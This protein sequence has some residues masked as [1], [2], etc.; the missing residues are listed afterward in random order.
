M[1]VETSN[2]YNG[3]N[4][5]QLKKRKQLIPA[6]STNPVSNEGISECFQKFSTSLYLSL[7]PCHISNPIN[8]IKSQHLDS[9]IMTYFP[10]AKGVCLAYSNIKI[11]E[12]NVSKDT[13]DNTITVAKITDSSPFTF[14]WV[15]VDF[16]IWRPQVGDVLEGYIYMQ[17]ASHIGLLVHDT[18]NAS[19]KKF[20]IPVDW[21][22]IPSQEDEYSEESNDSNKFK[23]FGYWVDENNVKIEGKLKFTIKSIHTTGKVVSLDGTLIKPGSERDAQPIFRE[24]RSSSSSANV[25]QPSKHKKFDE[26]DIPTVTE[27]PEPKDNDMSSFPGYSKSSDDEGDNVVINNSDS[28][29]E[30]SD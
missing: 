10:K 5:P 24:R 16:L 21:S 14:L 8:G 6:K 17:T 4:E 18:F 13:D 19:I 25:S 28:E 1:S 7:A 30:E 23:S 29:E 12:D 26:E 11:S 3:S 15:S 2:V 9:M 20:N 27:I 22:F